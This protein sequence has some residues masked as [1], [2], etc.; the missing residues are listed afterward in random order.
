MENLFI[1]F[2]VKWLHG[3]QC[4]ITHEEFMIH[5][6]NCRIKVELSEENSQKRK[7]YFCSLVSTEQTFEIKVQIRFYSVSFFYPTKSFT[8]ENEFTESNAWSIQTITDKSLNI[9]NLILRCRF[10]YT[11]QVLALIKPAW[12]K[13]FDL[14]HG[15]VHL[16][17]KI[18]SLF[19]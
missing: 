13:E 8:D 7:A 2:L 15:I 9:N 5:L 16:I 4:V 14:I 1:Y 3:E 19:T 12:A 17:I 11:K 18:M 10:N 6:K